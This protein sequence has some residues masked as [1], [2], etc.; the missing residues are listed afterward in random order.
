MFGDDDDDLSGDD[1]FGELPSFLPDDK[2][3]SN[4]S[5][6]SP[7]DT[8]SPRTTKRSRDDFDAS[9]REFLLSFFFSR[10]TDN[11]TPKTL[12]F[13]EDTRDSEN[14]VVADDT[15]DSGTPV[16]AETPV[17]NVDFVQID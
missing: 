13:D 14:P 6:V 3:R 16:V 7:R 11:A 10:S 17:V 8:G 9:L 2:P 15:N 12:E 1:L 4:F 5:D